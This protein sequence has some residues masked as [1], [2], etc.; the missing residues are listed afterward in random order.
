MRMMIASSLLLAL[1]AGCGGD[2]QGAWTIELPFVADEAC[3]DVVDHDFI[4]AVPIT[5]DPAGG[6]D[7]G[8]DTG[9]P[10]D[11]TE[12]QSTTTRLLYARIE[13]TAG[14][15]AVLI[16]GDEAWLG[17]QQGDGSWLFSWAG[18]DVDDRSDSHETGYALTESWRL[19]TDESITL[20]VSGD[21]G[22]GTWAS[23][24]AEAHTWT[25]PDSWAEA[26]GLDPGQIPAASYL[27][28][29]DDA[30]L[31]DPGDPVVNTRQGQECDDSPCRLSVEHACEASRDLS[32]TRARY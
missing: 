24:T 1:A 29:A 32:L 6:A 9:V 19:T 30:Q 27:R 11:T 7:T 21:G 8:A 25:E 3:A 17:Q 23:A 28:Y 22:T 10:L 5:D 12:D 13:Q 15:S 26:V 14:S 2:V 18:E 31:F 16:L 20:S 4:E